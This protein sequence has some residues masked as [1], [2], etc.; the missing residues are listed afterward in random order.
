MAKNLTALL[1]EHRYAPA[2][3]PAREVECLCGWVGPFSEAGDHV[4]VVVRNWIFSKTSDVDVVARW[5]AASDS[6]RPFQSKW[7]H[8]ADAA[9]VDFVMRE[10][11]GLGDEEK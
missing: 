7:A 4:A 6:V 8:P 2:E 10:L 1:T 11:L 3:L 9:I 5:R